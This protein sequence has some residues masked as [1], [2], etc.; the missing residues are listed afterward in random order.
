MAFFSHLKLLTSRGVASEFRIVV[1]VG[2]SAFVALT[3]SGCGST[4]EKAST[5]GGLKYEPEEEEKVELSELNH[6]QVREE[7]QELLDLFEDDELKEQIERRI[8]DVYMIEGGQDLLSLD[9]KNTYFKEAIKTYRDILV[10][11]PNSPSNAEAYYQLA[12]AYDMEGKQREALSMLEQLN[13]K[14]PNYINISEARFRMG[15]IYFSYQKYAEA[16][17]VYYAVTQ[18]KQSSLTL[19]AHYMLGWAY[20]KQLKF[21][22]AL[23]QFSYVLDV[24][25]AGRTDLDALTSSERTLVDDTLQSLSLTLARSGGAELISTVKSLSEQK[26]AWLVYDKL[27]KYYLE[28]ERYEDTANT[29][30]LFVETFPNTPRAPEIQKKLIESYIKGGFPLQAVNEK[31]VY[32][33]KYGIYSKYS[34]NN[35]GVN[36]EI[37]STIKEYL[38]ELAKHYHSNGQHLEKTLKTLLQGKTSDYETKKQKSTRELVISAYDTAA[39]YYKQF[40]E[41]FPNDESVGELTFLKAEAHF[42]A[43]RYDSAIVEYQKVAYELKDKGH[44]NHGAEAGY[45]TIISYQKQLAQ[46][47]EGSK[48]A[49][50]LRLDTIEAM[51]KFAKVFPQDKRSDTVQV[52]AAEDLFAMNELERTI[53]VSKNTLASSPKLE[54]SLK[55]TV[56]SLLAHSYL[57]MN[58][59]QNAEVNYINQRNLVDK[60]SE[61]YREITEYVSKT[62]YKSAEAL[63]AEGKKEEA[64]AKLLTIKSLAPKSSVRPTAQ[65]DAAS[66]MLELEKWQAAIDE[67]KELSQLYPKF[68]YAEEF[69]RKIAFAYEKM[70]NWKKAAE[71]YQWLSENDANEEIKREA[72]YL[73]AGFYEKIKDHEMAITLYKQYAHGYEQPF[74]VQMEAQYHLATN[75]ITIGNQQ[76]LL[77]WLRRIVDG[78]KA[79]GKQRTDRS[80]WLAAW[81]NIK[82]GDYYAEQ[83]RSR[84]LRLPLD[85]SL[86]KKNK[87]LQD[88]VDRYQLAADSNIL[89]FVTLSS[90]RIAGLYEQFYIELQ[91]APAPKGLTKEEVVMYRGIIDEQASPFLN[92]SIE[93]HE[94]NVAHAWDGK[95]NEWVEKS[96]AELKKLKPTR[97]NKY[98]YDVSYGDEIR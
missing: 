45:A 39:D 13:T 97:Y 64:I 42:S 17:D 81:A 73:A 23:K 16:E 1:F 85:K 90:Y 80:Q 35:D 47:K 6:E 66:M 62:I 14:H 89:D 69:P 19:N 24:S 68:T 54:A 71:S 36:K 18:D 21:N 33:E 88:A 82:Y 77:F 61:D 12:K 2:L 92:L 70:E 41:T 53:A 46:L 4:Q 9:P 38:M 60:Q 20:Y 83:F 58:D 26:V 37:K 25:L 8:G 22:Q 5:L 55:K 78:D 63:I 86:P 93:L 98:E 51:L 48:G 96:F 76:N 67:L 40:I 75:Y 87:M 3:I 32:V 50:K 72:L 11:Y 91:A 31:E 74:D 52:N 94:A 7:Y 84:K 57:K 34:G 95:H 79:A 59:Y 28:K 56:Y 44:K 15:D 65:Y 49:G 43:F 27:A 29:Y 10:K 30:R